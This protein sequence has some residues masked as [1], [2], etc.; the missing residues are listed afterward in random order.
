MD[1]TE[2]FSEVSPRQPSMMPEFQGGALN[3]WD[4]PAEG[5]EAETDESFVNFYY[6][7]NVA[8]RVTILGLYMIHGGT[9][10]GWI[11]APLLPK[12]Y[13]Y[14]AAIAE[15]RTIGSK[16]YEIKSLAL[17]TR[18]AKNLTKT[19]IVGNSTS[20]SD[21]EAIT[22]IELRNPDT[23]AGFYA[24]RHTDPTSNDEQ[25]LRLSVRASAGNFTVPTVS[26]NDKMSLN[27]HVENVLVTDFSFGG[28]NLVYSTA[29]V[30]TYGV[31]D[32]RPTLALWVFNGEGGEFFIEGAKSG[33][34][35][36]GDA[37]KVQFVKSRKGLVVNLKEQAGMT[38]VT[39]DNDVRVLLMDRNT[40]HLFW[41]PPLTADPIVPV[42]QVGKFSINF[43]FNSFSDCWASFR[44]G[45]SPG[46]G[47]AV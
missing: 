30:M 11:G 27:G 33:S 35:V 43:V 42:D 47:S 3:P 7:D 40:A 24:I 26:E 16:Y 23:D 20:Y 44:P 21:N 18:V 12:S 13:G 10:W 37:S 14:S 6:R 36:R 29:E 34:A 2:H 8:Q 32:S 41:V 15:N 38:V 46:E 31:F 39:T 19:D 9:N 17:F 4:G 25:S 1:Y 28:R 45:P 5:C 22:T